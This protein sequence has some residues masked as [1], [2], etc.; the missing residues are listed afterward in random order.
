MTQVTIM[1]VTSKSAVVSR[2][3]TAFT[4]SDLALEELTPCYATLD[5]I[6]RNKYM[7]NLPCKARSE[8]MIKRS[9]VGAFLKGII[10]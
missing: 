4:H 9:L 8:L 3:L 1:K 7:T 6:S 5:L 10:K 2:Y